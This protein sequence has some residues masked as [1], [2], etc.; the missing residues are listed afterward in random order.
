ML[1]LELKFKRLKNK[2]LGLKENWALF[3]LLVLMS[4]FVGS[5]VGFERS[6]LPVITSNW[7]L[8]KVQS[9][10]VMVATFGISKAIANLFTGNLLISLGRKWTLTLGWLIAALVPYLLLTMNTSWMAVGANIALGLSQGIT[11]STTV[12]MKIDIVGKKL[13]GTAM[14]LNESAG[15]FAI[16][17]VSAL[18]ASFM[19]ADGD[20]RFILFA[21]GLIVI[22]ALVLCLLFL[23][24]TKSWALIEAEEYEFVNEVP[25]NTF[26]YTTI[27]NRDLRRISFGGM[28][29]NAN[30]GI[31]WA[32]LPVIL[33]SLNTSYTTI[34]YLT[35]IHAASWGI[36]QLF[37][38]PLSNNG[39]IHKLCGYG[40]LLQTTGFFLL[41]ILTL[42]IL[43]YLLIGIGTA[44]V[45]PTFLV[46]ISNFSHPSWR[47]KA[48]AAYRFSR[49]IGYVLGAFAGFFASWS[50][51][52]WMAFIT[53]GILTMVSG[54]S[55]LLSKT[56]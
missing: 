18:A 14:G 13:R 39:N 56:K 8:P 6:L 44:L 22:I 11:W 38:G 33:L 35:G 25:T 15:Y 51:S 31:L 16:G 54:F 4:A 9:S 36:G 7:S 10:L 49:D 45:Y 12:I 20:F 43:P 34:G 29:N 46:G 28:V 1:G 48:L 55:F 5:M 50:N 27:T 26:L 32:M 24:D 47:P 23:P 19:D 42:Q 53:I 2:Q 17:I 3:T 30:D 21:S 37:T 52:K 40:M 41:P